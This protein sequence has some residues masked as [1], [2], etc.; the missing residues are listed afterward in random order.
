[1]DFLIFSDSHGRPS[2]IRA[3]LERQVTRPRAIFFAGDGLRD[4]NA[5]ELNG[6]PLYA[7]SGNCD[8]FSPLADA[9]RELVM[10]IG[11]HTVLLTHGH[12]LGVK[13]GNGALLKRAAEVD[14]DI[15][16]FGHTHSPFYE[17]LAAGS[18]LFDKTLLRPMHLFNPG[19]IG[20]DGCFGT[21]TANGNQLLFAH[22]RL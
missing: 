16:L 5:V 11:S 20:M 3:A 22:G 9:P 14:A 13:G 6:I 8:V 2:N 4:W 18:V 15:V 10:S 21:L 7:V 12:L 17:T 19:S 1:M